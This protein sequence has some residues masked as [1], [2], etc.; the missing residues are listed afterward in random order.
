MPKRIAGQVAEDVSFFLQIFFLSSLC[1]DSGGRTGIK[2]G[3]L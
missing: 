1:G 2:G 3:L